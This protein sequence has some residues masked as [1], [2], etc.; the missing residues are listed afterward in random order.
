MSFL[1]AYAHFAGLVAFGFQ[2]GFIARY[3]GLTIAGKVKLRVGVDVMVVAVAQGILLAVSD[4]T[5][6]LQSVR[7]AQPW[8]TV[9]SAVLYTV[10]CIWMHRIFVDIGTQYRVQVLAAERHTLDRRT[11]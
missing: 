1:R 8:R 2:L 5:L 4:I 6:A 7:I 11:P 10:L 9:L 3:A